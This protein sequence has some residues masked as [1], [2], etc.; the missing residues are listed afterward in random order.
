MSL[1]IGTN[2]SALY[3][4]N[5]LKTNARTTATTMERLSTGVRVNN[6]KDDAAGLA[7]G[8]NMT[9]KIRGLDQAVRNIN[10]GINLVQTAEGGLNSISNMLQRM[11]ELAVQSANGTYSDVQREYLNKE[12]QQL[13]TTIGQVVDTTMWNDQKLLDGSFSKPIQIGS[14][15]GA[16]MDITIP[17]ASLI[18]STTNSAT[19]F[20]PTQK[21]G[22]VVGS[23]AL[24]SGDLTI[25]STP[26]GA[27]ASSAKDV[28]AAINL[29][30][31]TTGVTAT[32]RATASTA[33]TYNAEGTKVWTNLLGTIGDDEAYALTTGLDGSIYVSGYTTGALDGQTYSGSRDAFLTKYSADGTKAW[34]KLLGTNGGDEAY[35]LTTGLDGSIYVSGYT[36]GAL[37]GQTNSGGYDAFLTKYS[38]DGTKDWTKLLGSS[39]RDKAVALTT[40]LDGSI[41]VSGSTDGALDGQTNSGGYDAFLTKYSADGTKDWTKLLG[42]IGDDKAVALTTGLD[43]SIYVSGSTDGA[44]DGQTNSGGYDAFLTKYSADGTK[45]WTKLL[46]S[47]GYDESAAL[48]TGLDGSIYVSGSTNGAL[49]GQTNWGTDAFL[50]KYSADGTKDWTKLLGESGAEV[51]LALTTGLDGSIY[52]G[53]FTNSALD[54]QTYSGSNDAFLTKYSADGT[55][56]WTKLMGS[57]RTDAIFALTTGLDGSVYV[58]GLASDRNPVNNRDVFDAFLTKFSILSDAIAADAIR[59]NGT[60]IGAIGTASTAQQRSTQMAAAINAVSTSTGVSAT[61]NTSTG[62]VTLSAADG[63]NI[64][65]STLSSAAITSNQTGIA[66]SGSVSGDRTVTT[67]RS[68]I[69]LNSTSSTGIVVIASASGATATGLTTGTVTPTLNTVTTITNTDRVTLD[70]STVDKSSSSITAID[71]TIDAVNNTRATL[72]SYINRLA[73]AADNVTNISSNSMQ[74]RSTIIDTD[75][76]IETTS[77]AKNQI[78]Q[79]A[80]TAMLAQANTQPQAVM[81]LLKNA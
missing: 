72:G 36:T 12:C 46:G 51:A 77:L 10:D 70:L 81:A 74:S 58:G 76:A 11:R 43:G 39:G 54:G 32:A 60:D 67:F 26:I 15:V 24:A 78:I 21:A 20:S 33:A 1:V 28:A 22:G 37:D 71:A 45:D 30:T 50:T 61:A 13:K 56:D 41:Y 25:N 79:Q 31:S 68:G 35:A 80:A 65:I 18:V 27:A 63:R 69:D 9:S 73:Y 75:Y 57:S 44:L 4:Q 48:T 29:Q 6:A 49:D 34:T 19:T 59:I 66:L 5:A 23:T 8:Q 14:D 62:G 42:T 40:G 16:K 2:V 53:G 47:V 52:V 17:S 55:K 7:I 64:E 3:S 38:A